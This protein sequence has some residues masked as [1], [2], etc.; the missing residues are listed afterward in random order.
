MTGPFAIRR[1]GPADRDELYRQVK[2]LAT[3][4]G[5]D[6]GAITPQ[7][8]AAHFLAP[9]LPM[10][11]LVA[12]APDGAI[13]GYAAAS[14]T[15]ESGYASP[16][17][18][19][20]D[21]H[22]DAEHRGAGLGRALLAAMAAETRRAGRQHIWWGVDTANHAAETWYRSIAN[23]RVPSTVFALTLDPFESLADEGERHLGGGD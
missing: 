21:L 4:H 15:H 8:V 23:V 11:V 18:Y 12:A 5:Y 17:F 6:P 13:A 19:L 10:V 9:D 16:G 20:S 2:A 1:A 3:H 14:P 7:N 22:V